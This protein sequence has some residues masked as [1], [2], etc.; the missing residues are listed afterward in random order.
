MIG[1]DYDRVLFRLWSAAASHV[2]LE[3]LPKLVFNGLTE[4]SRICAFEQGEFR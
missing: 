3:G 4:N 2:W 1:G